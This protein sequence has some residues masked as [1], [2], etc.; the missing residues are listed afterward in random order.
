MVLPFSVA[1]Q[2]KEPCMLGLDKSPEIRG[3]RL[4][5]TISEV[6]A[7]YP[8]IVEPKERS[9]VGESTIY[10]PRSH[11]FDERL[12][13]I[14]SLYL[15]FFRGRLYHISVDYKEPTYWRELTELIKP[16]ALPDKGFGAVD[17]HGFSAMV[18]RHA[19]SQRLTLTDTVAQQKKIELSD[20]LKENSADCQH[21]PV[22]RNVKLGMT[23]NQFKRLYPRAQII[24]KRL[25]VGELVLRTIGRED[26]RLNGIGTL[27]TYFLDD[28]L[29]FIVIDYAN[30]VQWKDIDQFVEH[31]SKPFG[32]R[33][34]WEGSTFSETR[35]LRCHS[36][37]VSAEMR[38]ANPRVTIQDRTAVL[39][40]NRREEQL[41]S[42]ANFRP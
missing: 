28:A 42:P 22:M 10:I 9:E 16:L 30:Q 5:M 38:A 34:K 27:W 32:L 41:K 40:L 2:D 20:E 29:Y 24:K 12:K 1:G 37:V 31:F 21:A 13:G 25:E 23:A 15:I 8:V 19:N 4:G 36:F 33:S 35:A 18:F 7:L 39:Q 17:C 14:D 6:R 11:S 3:L 26:Q